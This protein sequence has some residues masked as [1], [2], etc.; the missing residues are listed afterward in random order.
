MTA[1]FL[2]VDDA[3]R[4]LL[5]RRHRGDARVQPAGDGHADVRRRRLGLHRGRHQ[6]HHPRRAV[7]RRVRRGARRPGHAG[8]RPAD[9][10]RRAAPGGQRRAVGGDHRGR[11]DDRA[12]VRHRRAARPRAV[13]RHLR[14]RHLRAHHRAD[15]RAPGCRQVHPGGDHVGWPRWYSDS[16]PRRSRRASAGSCSALQK[17]GPSLV[18]RIPHD[19]PVLVIG[20]GR[21]GAGAAGQL[22]RLDR[23]VL[24]V[25]DQRRA[26][27]EVVGAGHPRRAGGL[28]ET[29]TRCARS[30]PR[31][32]RSP[33][34][35]S[36]RRSRR[37]C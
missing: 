34:S 15:R 18:D 16:W 36:A 8:V 13:R 35:P 5:H 32:S 14:V 3:V 24:A 10:L 22:A 21:F 12:A 1:S 17:R 37:A 25:D 4:R 20:L 9:P 30:A 7:P 19:A 33:S 23:E 6:G 2:S 27:A 28:P 31:T 26:R 11:L 29:S